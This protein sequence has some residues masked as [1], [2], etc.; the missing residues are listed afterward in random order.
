MTRTSLLKL[1]ILTFAL[2]LLLSGCNYKL[3][4]QQSQNDYG[5]RQPN[6]PK[7]RYSKA[8]GSQ[9]G[10]PEQHNNKFF[11]Y[12]RENSLAVANM[13][14]VNN[15]IVMLTDKNAYVAVTLD[16]AATGVNGDGSVME[17]DNGGNTEGVYDRWTGSP[18]WD[19]RD[20]A[21]PYNSYFTVND[22]QQI[23]SELKQAIALKVRKHS[24]QVQEVHIS[25]NMDF[26]NLMSD[27]AKAAWS[28]EPLAPL[29]DDFN[30]V[31]Q[32]FF[33]GGDHMPLPAHHWNIPKK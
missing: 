20:V 8:Y 28:G 2:S 7:T 17:Q 31:V 22:H 18:Y 19:N 33:A 25:A 24:P 11:E 1:L 5:S 3:Q 12:S 14:G 32:H 26:N 16:W 4:F 15:A 21:T 9:T 13:D 23:S 27:F 10:D 6:D 29:T 30:R